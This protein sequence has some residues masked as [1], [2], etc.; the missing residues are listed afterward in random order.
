MGRSIVMHL[1]IIQA[2]GVCVM[3]WA[4]SDRR[5]SVGMLRLD[6]RDMSRVTVRGSLQCTMPATNTGNACALQLASQSGEIFRIFRSN[7]A[8]RL[9]HDG[10][11]QVVATGTVFGDRFRIIDIRSE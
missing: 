6:D 11:T 1:V 10:K 7:P 2:F 8:M 9:Y 3:A 4:G 5:E